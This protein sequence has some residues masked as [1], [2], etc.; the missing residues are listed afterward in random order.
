MTENKYLHNSILCSLYKLGNT[1][2]CLVIDAGCN[3][4]LISQDMVESFKLKIYARYRACNIWWL[5]KGDE[6]HIQNMFLLNFFMGNAYKD[7]VWC[8]VMQID[9]THVLLGNRGSII[10]LQ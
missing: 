6:V 9:A 1:K 7:S 4:G 2:A 10:G 3:D 8:N 5:G